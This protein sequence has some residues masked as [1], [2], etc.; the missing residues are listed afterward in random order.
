MDTLGTVWPPQNHRKRDI[1]RPS[2]PI[3]YM[4]GRPVATRFQK[5]PALWWSKICMEPALC[6]P[7]PERAGPLVVQVLPI[8]REGEVDH[9][10]GGR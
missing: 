6:D 4:W 3:R 8:E 2:F 5:G 10:G 1:G 7:I 9:G